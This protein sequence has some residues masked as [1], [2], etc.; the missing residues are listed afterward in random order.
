MKKLSTITLLLATLLAVVDSSAQ[1]PNVIYILTDQWRASALGYAGDPNVLTP[2]IDKLAMESVNFS[3]ALSVS[4]VCT[5]HRAAL[6]TG[7]YPTTTGMFL[8]DLYL[9]DEEL[10]MAEIF[11][12]EGY[13]TAFY[14][15]W[16]LDGH[17]RL[18]NV[19][20]E[21]RQ[22]FDFWKAA[23]CSHDYNKMP[24]YDNN[25]PELKFWPEY[26]PFAI[27]KD[28]QNYLADQANSKKP[29][30]LFLSIATP[31]FPHGT[32]LQEYKDLYDKTKIKLAPNVGEEF[33][34]KAIE[35]LIGYYAHATATD[36][37]I[38]DL[39]AKIKELG[40][41]KNSIIVLSADH[42][43]MMGSHSVRPLSK[44]V[45]WDESVR[46]P[47]LISYP[48]IG[49]RAG[50]K[51]EEPLTTPDILPS[52]LGL[53]GIKI[54]KSVEGEDLSL[55]MKDP[56][57]KTNRAALIMNLCPF[58]REHVYQEYRGIYTN[59]YTYLKSLDGSVR[60]FDLKNDPYQMNDLA[61]NGE[62]KMTQAALDVML[63]KELRRI[64]DEFKPRDYYLKKFG[65]VL[66][67]K[68]T[69]IDYHGFRN[70]TG[71]TQSP[72]VDRAK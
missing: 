63:N 66:N 29:F 38:G 42:G 68:G 20:P 40:L 67:A 64:G 58:T 2:N 55:L 11:K 8:N 31:H 12:A 70:G 65:L 30:L 45:A 33:R 53:S 21:R 47:F 52:L 56:T 18:N 6:M 19:A 17:G 69:H 22:G 15:K 7:R 61:G 71:V 4:P 1:K 39:L 14:G 3:N 37:A 72:R 32:A 51:V 62:F 16:H 36:K 60:L 48:E 5:P 13:T 23:E 46:V 59:R 44:Q 35:E 54:P 24:Y 10:C 43:E 41:D 27:T 49:S 50:S 57:K 25:S 34:E 28:A 26:S 9:P